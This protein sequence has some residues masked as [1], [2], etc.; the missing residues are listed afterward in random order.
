MATNM[1]SKVALFEETPI[2]K[3]VAQLSIPIVIGSLVMILYNLADTFFVGMLNNPIQNAG[4]TLASPVLLAFN[5][6]T[7][8]F[9]VG[10]SSLMSR[11]LGVK[12]YET[13]KKT[14]ALAFWCAFIAAALFS[15]AYT[16]FKA[17]LL[18]ML[19]STDTTMQATEDYM[20][21]TVT[22]GDRKSVV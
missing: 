10:S 17:P 1:S 13:A 22:C 4:V 11:S 18:I 20:F 6:V 2:P 16:I 9:G 21:W 5:A 12:D 3:A 15:I 19:G 8:L 14:S 7:N